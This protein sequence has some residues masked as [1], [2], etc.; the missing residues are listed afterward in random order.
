MG[1]RRI[2]NRGSISLRPCTKKW[3]PLQFRSQ[4][5]I[6]APPTREGARPRACCIGWHDCYVAFR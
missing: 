5:L 6:E 1:L 2:T 3:T 4:R